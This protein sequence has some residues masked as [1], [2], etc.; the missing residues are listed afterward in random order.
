MTLKE[1]YL[2]GHWWY[3]IQPWLIRVYLGGKLLAAPIVGGLALGAGAVALG[4]G[5]VVLPF[6]GG[7]KL[8]KLVK[9]RRMEKEDKTMERRWREF[10]VREFAG[11]AVEEGKFHMLVFVTW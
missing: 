11:D 9:Q 1:K 2:G 5:L 10:V 8:H 4:L 6:Y 3:L 7:Y